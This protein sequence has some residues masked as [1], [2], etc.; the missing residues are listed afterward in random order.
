MGWFLNSFLELVI[1]VMYTSCCAVPILG[2]F[3][4]AMDELYPFV[5]YLFTIL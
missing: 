4:H 5:H 1:D 3:V 2:R